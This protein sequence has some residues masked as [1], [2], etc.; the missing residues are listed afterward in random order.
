[1]PR[2]SAHVKA[3]VKI[4]RA[5]S[6]APSSVFLYGGSAVSDGNGEVAERPKA[7]VC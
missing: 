6:L 3:F 7:A 2:A 1:M 4:A 5:C